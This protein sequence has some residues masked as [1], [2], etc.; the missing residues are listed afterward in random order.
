MV[1]YSINWNQVYNIDKSKEM[2]FQSKG[3]EFTIVRAVTQKMYQISIL[4]PINSIRLKLA[5]C[6]AHQ[7]LATTPSAKNQW[8]PINKN[9]IHYAEIV[10]NI[11]YFKGLANYPLLHWL[12]PPQTRYYEPPSQV[13]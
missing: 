11:C 10:N 4:Y 12:S 1:R 3:H 8:Y 9:D 7:E 5:S 2:W 13:V 6:Q